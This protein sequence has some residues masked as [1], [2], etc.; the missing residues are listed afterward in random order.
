M[1][2]GEQLP[3]R[4]QHRLQ[5][6]ILVALPQGD[7]ILQKDGHADGRNQRHQA[8]T[9][10]QRLVGNLLDREAVAAGQNDGNQN[11]E[12]DDQRQRQAERGQTHQRH[13]ADI[14]ANHV[15]L[16]VGEVNQ[17][18]DAIDHG[19]ANGNQRINAAE[20]EAVDNLL[21]EVV[22]GLKKDRVR[23]GAPLVR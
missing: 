10:A 6:D 9:V 1:V 16:A 19:V 12:D 11:G 13:H 21:K 8:R 14:S 20:G 18:D 4:G 5:G 15:N 3:A 2:I 17:A 7:E 23:R 22:H